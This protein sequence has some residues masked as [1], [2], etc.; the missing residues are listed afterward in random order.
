M[1]VAADSCLGLVTDQDPEPPK[2]T[3]LWNESLGRWETCQEG[4]RNER[5]QDGE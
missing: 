3:R 4:Q 2:F 1:G 5:G